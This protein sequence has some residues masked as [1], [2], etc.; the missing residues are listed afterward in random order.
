[1]AA[2]LAT[3]VLPS[4]GC[5]A[6]LSALPQADAVATA[7]A[8]SAGRVET[9]TL[10]DNH[11]GTPKAFKVYV[12][13]GYPN[14]GPYPTLYLFRGTVDEWLNPQQDQSRQGRTAVSVYEDLR[15]H[16]A[17][18]PMIL[19]FMGLGSDDGR[20]PG[21]LTD[22]VAPQAARTVGSGAFASY[23]F[24]DVIPAVD[25]RFRT[26]GTAQ[27]RAVD[28]FSLG[29][30][31]AVQAAASRPDRFAS[32]G[33]YDGTFLLPADAD[34][35]KPDDGV[36]KQGF[37][38]PVFGAPRQWSAVASASPANRIWQGDAAPLRK[39]TWM[40]EYG[41]EAAEPDDANYYRGEAL[42]K[43]LAGKGITNRLGVRQDGRH[44]W[45]TADEHLKATLPMHWQA[46]T[47]NRR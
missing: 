19:V 20:W 26:T 5:R 17:V 39:L 28:G 16:N 18:G 36:V 45:W 22:W 33:A 7:A 35:V 43:T 2:V 21:I 32:V 47:Q 6:S 4:A 40:I 34:H 30:W 10:A 24:D 41:P 8:R 11:L 37:L 27:A 31:A 1:V 15:R 44:N 14:D 9:V 25:K 3:L 12:P 29:G 23:F 42:I 38:D 46:M 13:A